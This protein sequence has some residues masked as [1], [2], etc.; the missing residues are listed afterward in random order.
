[1]SKMARSSM[2]QEEAPLPYSLVPRAKPAKIR[3]NVMHI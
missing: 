3:K 2:P 1:M